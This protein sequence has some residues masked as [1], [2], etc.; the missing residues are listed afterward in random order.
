[1]DAMGWFFR[2]NFNYLIIKSVF[3]EKCSHQLRK[4]LRTLNDNGIRTENAEETREQPQHWFESVLNSAAVIL[5]RKLHTRLVFLRGNVAQTR[6]Y[7]PN[8]R[9]SATFRCNPCANIFH[10]SERLHN[11]QSIRDLFAAN[12]LSNLDQQLSN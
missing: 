6:N 9:S 7:L 12:W 3:I 10:T 4:N 8:A 11:T 1:M 5:I 2:R